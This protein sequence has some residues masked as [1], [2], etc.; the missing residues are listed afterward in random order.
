MLIRDYCNG[1]GAKKGRALTACYSIKGFLLQ[2]L[3][4]YEEAK[5]AYKIALQIC[6]RMFG[7][8]GIEMSSHV[9]KIFNNLAS[10]ANALGETSEAQSLYEATVVMLKKQGKEMSIQM[11]IVLENLEQLLRQ[12]G[13]I[14][15]A[16][17]FRSRVDELTEKLCDEMDRREELL[18]QRQKQREEMN[19]RNETE[20]RTSLCMT[21]YGLVLHSPCC[22]EC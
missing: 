2:E 8:E 19:K 5:E 20:V 4:E 9:A 14:E 10:V 22:I 18:K 11:L 3:Q 16:D 15:N 17:F 21:S 1:L 13:K 6:G 12:E 7:K